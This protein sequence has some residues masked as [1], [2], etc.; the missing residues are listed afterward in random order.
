M[1]A[2]HFFYLFYVQKSS[3]VHACGRAVVP[4]RDAMDPSSPPPA[5]VLLDREGA[6]TSHGRL[7]RHRPA[8]RAALVYAC[9]SPDRQT[10]RL[11][12]EDAPSDVGIWALGVDGDG[13]TAPAASGAATVHGRRLGVS[14]G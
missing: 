13:W 3:L 2:I 6:G 4:P 14:D 5:T 8:A 12:G 10:R 1:I 9:T 7:S 11:L